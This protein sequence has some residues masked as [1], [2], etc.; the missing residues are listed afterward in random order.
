MISCLS[1]PDELDWAEW[2]AE[3]DGACN[4]A[5]PRTSQFFFRAW[6]EA[7]HAREYH[8]RRLPEDEAEDEALTKR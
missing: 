6:Q 7:R 4:T 2:T 1:N 5:T 3:E 8:G